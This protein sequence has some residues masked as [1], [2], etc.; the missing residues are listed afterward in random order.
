VEKQFSEEEI[1]NRTIDLHDNYHMGF[2][3][4][5]RKLSMEG[6]K[7]NKDKA[8]RLYNKY[9]PLKP[10]PIEEDK[11]LE[12]LKNKEE[13]AGKGL[14][15]LKRK[16]ELRRNIVGFTVQRVMEDF[17]QRRRIFTEEDRLLKFA[18]KTL[19]VTDPAVWIKFSEYCEIQ[20][21]DLAKTL[22]A[23]LGPQEFF[24]EQLVGSEKLS[25]DVYLAARMRNCLDAW[26]DQAEE[27]DS[28]SEQEPS[29][30]NET[31]EYTDDEGFVHI[32]IPNY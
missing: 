12:E 21:I 20:G 32:E 7:I 27:N 31:N 18:K 28:P 1:A 23:V 11:E 3:K 29:E 15:L 14:E 26:E 4:I 9:K 17:D 24:E 30:E 16:N 19:R 10:S 2:R 6:C 8:W 13:K 22:L 5:A 25:L